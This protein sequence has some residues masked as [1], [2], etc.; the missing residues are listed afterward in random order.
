M[1]GARPR[2]GGGAGGETEGGTEVT[3]LTARVGILL[4]RRTLQL[5][6][7]GVPTYEQLELYRDIALSGGPDLV[8]FSLD[9]MNVRTG[10]VRG[11]V[12]TPDG[13]KRAAV[14]LPRVVHKR[15]SL[16]PA[17]E[18]ALQRLHGH[19][20]VFIN[21]P[22]ISDKARMYRALMR[23]PTV[24][25]HVPLTEWY[26]AELLARWLDNGATI[27]LKPRIGSVG[28]GVTR[29]K[30]AGRAVL[31]TDASG[32]QV[33]SVAS[34][35]RRLQR[36]ARPRWHLL[37]QY[38]PLARWR[39]RP[40]DLR[41]P[42]QRDADGRWTVA[43]VVAKV[44]ERHPFLTNLAQG[45]R[46]LPADDVLAQA[47]SPARAEEI[48]S[49]VRQLAVAAA[50]AVAAR[51]PEAADLGLDVGVDQDGKPWV[52]EVNARDQ[53]ITFLRAGMRDALR[54]V[55]EQPLRYCAAAAGAMS[56]R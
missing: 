36:M 2:R 34:L 8:L 45:G 28:K 19:G 6:R 7:R 10:R 44:A 30:P 42:A 20:V 53:R 48:L 26:D 37:Q 9:D 5:A 18:R 46:A 54:A 35:V 4:D 55:Y 52:I 31:V 29:I 3:T 56:G 33:F 41:V 22:C 11:Y 40:F 1:T 27:I 24:A 16:T 51:F 39:S 50:E 43:G 21:P 14:P 15:I 47:F 12:P 13:W 32:T 38:I 49:D 25:D 17:V 23:S